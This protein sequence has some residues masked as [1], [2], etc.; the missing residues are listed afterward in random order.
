M[1]RHLEEQSS[2]FYSDLARRLTVVGV[3]PASMTEDTFRLLRAHFQSALLLDIG[4]F[5][6][7]SALP[8]P[9]SWW[10]KHLYGTEDEWSLAILE[11][12]SRNAVWVT[13]M[14]VSVILQSPIIRGVWLIAPSAW[15]VPTLRSTSLS[16]ALL[17]WG[18]GGHSEFQVANLFRAG[19]T[20]VLS[21][22]FHRLTLPK[23]S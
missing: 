8:L 23:F 6:S 17:W 18:P 5:R 7:L 9:G 1:R 10:R 21:V 20:C 13:V 12:I 4:S 2:P 16:A 3:T 15:R 14:I 19:S 11:F 22:G